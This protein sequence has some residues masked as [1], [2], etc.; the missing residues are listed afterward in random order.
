MNGSLQV[1]LSIFSIALQFM[2]LS[3]LSYV[4]SIIPILI[5]RTF[6]STTPKGQGC[7]SKIDSISM[8]VADIRGFC[9]LVINVGSTV[10]L[11]PLTRSFF[12]P[13]PALW[14]WPCAWVCSRALQMVS[15]G[16][17]A[18]PGFAP[19][20]SKLC[21]Q[22]RSRQRSINPCSVAHSGTAANA[23]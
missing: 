23:L 21:L 5:L 13:L 20:P 3:Q 4:V 7:R 9:F 17:S 22:H 8:T 1:V 15:S 6:I 19:I 14:S 2:V 10:T 16:L 11:S 12:L 18:R